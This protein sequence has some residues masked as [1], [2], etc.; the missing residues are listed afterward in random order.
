MRTAAS[1]GLALALARPA[2]AAEPK[3]EE[4]KKE[5]PPATVTA[6]LGKGVTI[7]SK[8]DSFSLNIRARMQGRFEYVA[9][10]GEESE[11]R[12]MI[13]R[14]RLV[15]Q[16]HALTPKL[17]YYLQLGFSNLDT[18]ADLRLPLRDAYVAWAPLR[19][20][21]VRGGQMKVPFGRQR[22]TSSSSLELVDRSIIISELS[23]DRDVG[24]VAFSK[25]FLGLGDRFGYQLGVF[26]GDGRNRVA[27]HEGALWVARLD[28]WPNGHF[29]DFSE[30]DF[31][32]SPKPRVAASITA[33]YNQN[34]YRQRSTIGDT[35]ELDGFDYLHGAADV[36][37]KWRG[38]TA[39]FE[40]QLRSSEEDSHT[41]NASGQTIT[42]YSRSGG[43]FFL[44]LSQML[45]EH[46]QIAG[47]YSHLAPLKQTDPGFRSQNELGGSTSWYFKEHALKLQ[48]DYFYLFGSDPEIG[49]H[50][51]RV[52]GQLYF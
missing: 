28:F 41:G 39:Q 6:G 3:K 27:E 22:V 12:F 29:D 2:W 42:E 31:A 11:T 19:D 51:L 26:G 20:L 4:P 18:E 25:N 16:G 47:R 43:G 15:F 44:Q 38:M 10:D 49:R 30:A 32:R 34:S 1:V 52:Q 46:L 5:A 48:A 21:A 50:Q 45:T 33:A 35:Y 24:V 17:T 9:E 14:A 23:L 8:D 40:A 37:I 7:R 13:R 36:M